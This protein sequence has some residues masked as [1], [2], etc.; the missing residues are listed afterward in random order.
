M[1]ISPCKQTRSLASSAIVARAAS[2]AIGGLIGFVSR[3]TPTTSPASSAVLANFEIPETQAADTQG[4]ETQMEDTQAPTDVEP[5]TKKPKIQNFN[6][7]EDEGQQGGGDR[8]IFRRESSL[9]PR[10][11]R[12]R[13]SLGPRM[14]ANAA[15]EGGILIFF[16]R[17]L[18][19]ATVQLCYNLCLVAIS[20]VLGMFH[21]LSCRSASRLV[22]L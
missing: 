14:K 7:P 6:W 22:V 13:I 12:F 21:S 10:S 20:I 15:R 17:R 18:R 11:L 8:D 1:W 4:A 19:L 9:S 16:R 5:V 3:S 2:S